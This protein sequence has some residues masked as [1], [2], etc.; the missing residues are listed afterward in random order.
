MRK[1][2]IRTL[3]LTADEHLDRIEQHLAHARRAIE[4]GF[5][6]LKEKRCD[7]AVNDYAIANNQY[8]RAAAHSF[9]SG[10]PERYGKALQEAD[11]D[12]HRLGQRIEEKC[13]WT[14]TVDRPLGGARKR[15]KRA[16]L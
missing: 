6:A 14:P 3:G 1:K 12:L 5:Q 16:K 4:T 9:S 8:G 15:A 10:Q 11:R 2:A 13:R 7:F